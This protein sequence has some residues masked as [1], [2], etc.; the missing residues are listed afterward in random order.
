M[1]AEPPL[2]RDDAL[3][4]RARRG[5]GRRR[6]GRA[7]GRAGR[8][9]RRRDRSRPRAATES[10]RL[11]LTAPSAHPAVSTIWRDRPCRSEILSQ[12]MTKRRQTILR[13]VDR[14][15]RD[16]RVPVALPARRRSRRGLAEIRRCPAGAIAA[17][18]GFV[19][20]NCG[21]HR[22]ALALPLL[23]GSLPDHGSARCFRIFC[24]G[25]G[26]N[27][28]LPA[29]GGDLLRIESVRE[30]YRIPPFVTAGTLFA[31]RLLDGVVLSVWILM[32]ALWIGETGHAAPRGHRPLGGLRARDRA[33]RRS[34]RGARSGPRRSSGG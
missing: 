5:L 20:L 27:N 24:V 14:H 6:E 23:G 34:R 4:V 3:G 32:G 26:A 17:A 10:V 33:R 13:L 29:R 31:E 28:I 21:V 9:H 18:L 15:G 12:R 22:S 16:R 11:R 30:H 7:R 2:E 8:R 19:L 25:A 1:D